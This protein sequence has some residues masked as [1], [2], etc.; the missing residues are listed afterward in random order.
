MVEGTSIYIT[1]LEDSIKR[2]I[3][4]SYCEESVIIGLG[5]IFSKFI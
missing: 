1:S 2:K 3:S 4:Q 5:R